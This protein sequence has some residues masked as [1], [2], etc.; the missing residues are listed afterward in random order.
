MPNR[1]AMP[2]ATQSCIVDGRRSRFRRIG[3]QVITSPQR[4]AV[5]TPHDAELPAGERFARVPL[6]L[7]VLDQPAGARTGLAQA[8]REVERERSLRLTV[9]GRVPLGSLHVVDRHERR[10]A[11]HREAHV[12]GVEALVDLLAEFVDRAPTARACT[13]S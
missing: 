3:E 11:A 9:G 4:F 8:Q 10:F 2:S 1:A 7:P 6:A 12:A 13:A 5:V